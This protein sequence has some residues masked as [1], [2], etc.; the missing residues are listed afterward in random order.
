MAESTIAGLDTGMKHGTK[1]GT[2]RGTETRAVAVTVSTHLGG[3]PY[4]LQRRANKYVRNLT[5]RESLRVGGLAKMMV[6]RGVSP[7]ER[8]KQLLEKGILAT[9]HLLG[10]NQSNN[11]NHS[12][13][14]ILRKTHVRELDGLRVSTSVATGCHS[15]SIGVPLIDPFP[16]IFMNGKALTGRVAV[17][18]SIATFITL[19]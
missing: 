7:P 11:R 1:H 15:L 8:V 16:R 19:P 9:N 12:N 17:E 13:Q 5:R 14:L 18:A 2:K 3:T 10:A 4:A 6:G